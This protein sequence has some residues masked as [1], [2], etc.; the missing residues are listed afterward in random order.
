MPYSGPIYVSEN[1]PSVNP[2]KV[3]RKE[4]YK[5]KAPYIDVLPYRSAMNETFTIPNPFG[6]T[7]DY[8]WP[9]TG[10]YYSPPNG[11]AISNCYGRFREQAKSS[12]N[13]AVNIAERAQ[14]VD[15]IA[16][17]AAQA[18]R[19][20]RAVRS[21]RLSEAAAAIGGTVVKRKDSRSSIRASI[22]HK[23]KDYEVRLK[24]NLKS[25]GDNYLEFHFGWEPLVKDIGEGIEILHEPVF[26]GLGRRIKARATVS[27]SEPSTPTMS[28]FSIKT[29]SYWPRV[30]VQMIGTVSVDDPNTLRLNQL[31]F[32]NP[33][34]VAW[35]LVPF[36]FVVDWFSN[37]GQVLEA[38]TDF[39]GMSLKNACTTT[40]SE[41]SYK[42]YYRGRSP[43]NWYGRITAA[44]MGGKGRST[45]R[46][47]GIQSPSLVFKPPKWPSVT[48]A[49]TAI[50][51][52]TQFLR[53]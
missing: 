39:V 9:G 15:M 14:A 36:S 40:F 44:Y 28:D 25:F 53:N 19:L 7:T 10:T 38:Y 21:L 33:A 24:K 52:L 48:R 18:L 4:R 32:I 17:R 29:T 45:I 30:S 51:L 34:V 5:Q 20:A 49:A 12:V 13:L 26:K 35:E 16:K 3:V 43:T 11:V 47:L 8:S 23:D 2:T 41:Y 6:F 31:G 37:V 46:S 42:T 50:S 1:Y 22:R 27:G